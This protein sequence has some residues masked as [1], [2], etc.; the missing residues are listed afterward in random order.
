MAR[1]IEFYATSSRGPFGIRSCMSRGFF[2]AVVT[3]W[4]NCNVCDTLFGVRRP[5]MN[6]GLS[7][8]TNTPLRSRRCRWAAPHRVDMLPLTLNLGCGRLSVLRQSG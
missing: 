6:S 2:G 3:L 1:S 5:S 7:R 4:L 8:P